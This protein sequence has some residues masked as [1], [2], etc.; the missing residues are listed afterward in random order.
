M[1]KDTMCGPIHGSSGHAVVVSHMQNRERL[2]KMVA[3]G[4]SSSPKKKKY[5]QENKK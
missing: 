4:L 3:Q 5:K 2:T 1:I